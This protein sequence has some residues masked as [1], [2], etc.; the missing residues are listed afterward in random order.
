MGGG[1]SEPNFEEGK[2]RKSPDKSTIPEYSPIKN[3][4][5]YTTKS[6]L[7][8]PS[9]PALLLPAGKDFILRKI[10]ESGKITGKNG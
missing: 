1:N 8:S 7:P 2:T 10:D 9:S 5:K 3:A 4:E 6:V